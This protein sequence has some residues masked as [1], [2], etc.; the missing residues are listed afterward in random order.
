NETISISGMPSSG[1]KPD[2]QPARKGVLLIVDDEEGPRQSLHLIF[3]DDYEMLLAS[4]GATAIS[5][6]QKQRI[7]VA[8]CDIRMA[9]MSGIE[10][11]ERLKYVDP[12]IE[13]IMMTAFETTDT[14]RQA[15]R[16]RACD[17][18]NKP[19]DIS[20]MRAAVSNAMQKR[21]R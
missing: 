19:F 10:V 12:G 16:L 8:I 21:T 18:I 20:T 6:A 15:L 2:E 14:M 5:L 17:Y 1:S 13:V 3:K 11:L 9:G 7:D 4:D